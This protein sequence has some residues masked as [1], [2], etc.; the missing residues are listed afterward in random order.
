MHRT[1]DGSNPSQAA[2]DPRLGRRILLVCV[3]LALATA[4]VYW[5]VARNGFINF[6]DPDYLTAN[7]R[8]QA[9]LTT[10]SIRWAFTAL[11]ASNWHPLTW[12]SHMLDCQLYGPKPAGHHV[13]NLVLHIVNSLLVFGLL[14]RMTCALWRSALVAGLFTLHPLHVESVAWLSERKDVLSTCFGLLCLLA[15][16]RYAN[17]AGKSKIEVPKPRQL[18]NEG[19]DRR[20][21]ALVWYSLALVLFA[22][23]L[24]SKPMLVTLPCLL[25]LLDYWPLRRFPFSPAD[26]EMP[27][28]CQRAGIARLLIEKIPFFIL[29]LLSCVLTFLVQK[30]CGA[31]VPLANAPVE[32]RLANAFVAYCSYLWKTLWPAKLAVFYPFT[33]WDWTSPETIGAVLLLLAAT[34]GAL[35][36]AK[37]RPYLIVGWLWFLG[38]LVPV[39]GVVQVG[40]QAMADRYTYLP[41]I[42]LFLMV[43]WGGAAVISRLNWPR[44][45][46]LG[47]AV[48]VLAVLGVVTS[49]QVSYWRNT[50]TLFEHALAVTRGNY[51][52]LAVLGNALFEEGKL[53]DAIAHCRKALALSPGYPEALNSLGNIY[54]KQARYDEAIASYRA[55]LDSD[56]SYADAHNGLGDALMKQGKFADAEAQCRE[57]LR[58][59]PMH[60]P[61]MF[62]LA[63]AL[64]NQGKLDEAAKRYRQV[65]ALSPELFTPRRYLGNVLVAQGKPDEAIPEFRTALKI[66]PNDADTHVVL[67]IALLERSRADEATAQFAEAV[68]LQPTNAIANYQLGTIYQG[69]KQPHMAIDYFRKA[70]Q[71]QADWPEVLNN[72]AWILAANADPSVRDGA[73]AVTCAERACT[74]TS[75]KEPLLIGTLA[76]AY[77]EAGRFNDAVAAAEKARG[78]AAAATQTEVAEKNKQLLELYRAGRAYHEAEQ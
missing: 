61:A 35:V 53:D 27:A 64:H 20:G 28:L 18:Q 77:A 74:L 59:A 11:Y 19:N 12:L 69:R 56:S 31:M 36:V 48:G 62:C 49:L 15:Y 38:T 3:L 63:T 8:V 13:T 50:K 30:A 60:L 68:R 7:P 71:A 22:L 39:I 75:Y 4:A 52:A 57:A 65:L 17:G 54:S 78:L 10:D 47:A 9:G 29:S 26:A 45:V 33:Q 5:P 2:E 1:D 32:S 16:V 24:M 37:Q 51:V 44:S 6:D 23:G 25:L 73:E 46:A 72:L 42:G 43:V 34:A 41:H 40:R 55:A 58:L 66:R 67:G 70:L 14:R 21:T 76:A